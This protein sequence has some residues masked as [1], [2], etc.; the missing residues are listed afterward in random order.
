MAPW[1]DTP[2]L[3]GGTPS[4]STKDRQASKCA[5]CREPASTPTWIRTRDLQIRRYA[6][7]ARPAAGQSGDRSTDDFV[8]VARL[9]R[10]SDDIAAGEWIASSL[11]GGFGAVTRTVPSGFAAYARICHPATDPAGRLAPWREVVRHTGRT[12]HPLMQWHAI[13]GSADPLNM[14]GSLWPGDDPE[15]GN[16][17]PEVL[18][19][20]CD[21][22]GDHT[23]TPERCFFCLWEGW[24]WIRRSSGGPSVA[25]AAR[26]GDAP[27]SSDHPIAPPFSDDELRRPKMHL[28]GRDYLLLAGPLEA[29]LQIGH[30]L[31]PDCFVP[32]SPNLFWPADRAWCVASEIDFDSTLIGGTTELVNAILQTPEL[33]AWR[34]PPDASLAQDADRLNPLP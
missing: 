11:E 20:L 16:L 1:V 17:V 5:L 32:Q 4:P 9:V 6:R 30:W 28:P 24:G 8:M 27:V 18:E 26:A 33:E 2:V 19:R 13:V 15:R 25:R 21:V 14:T 3:L 31:S 12:V 10:V 29:A 34:V 7:H 22:L 23:A